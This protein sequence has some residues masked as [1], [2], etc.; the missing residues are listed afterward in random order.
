MLHGGVLSGWTGD[1]ADLERRLAIATEE[2]RALDPDVIGVQEASAGPGRGDVA[3]RLAGALGYRFVRAPALFRITP[4]RPFNDLVGWLM[5]FTE[6]PA[7]LSRYPIADTAAHDLPLCNGR[8]DPRVV[9][10]AAIATP[11]GTVPAFSAHLSWGACEAADLAA[12]VRDRRAALPGVLLGDFNAVAESPEM[13]RLV[14][15]A[16]LVDAFGVA[17]EGRGETVWQD[18]GRATRTVGRRVDF[19]FVAPGSAASAR[20][21]ESRVVLDQPR[22]LPDGGFLWPSDHYGV[23]ARLA[24]EGLG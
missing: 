10:Y 18:P 21:V 16:G 23:L 19:V 2:L 22:R 17:G 7:I 9:V 6:G 1:D 12:F 24:L 4:W 11:W 5:R 14:D 13:R 8:F 15:E 20:V 3:G